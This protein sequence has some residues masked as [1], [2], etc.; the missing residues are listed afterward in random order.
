MAQA[1]REVGRKGRRDPQAEEPTRQRGNR[2]L[3]AR[4]VKHHHRT[5]VDEAVYRERDQAS[6]PAGLTVHPHE[7]V[8]M[9][10]GRDRGDRR[11][12]DYRARSRPPDDPVCPNHSAPPAEIAN[13]VVKAM[14]I[15]Y[16]KCVSGQKHFRQ[17]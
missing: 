7:I 14:L 9:F 15:M 2:R 1:V 11:H 8:G 4:G 13:S 12:T 3:T 10:V 6:N 5:R 17:P 16:V